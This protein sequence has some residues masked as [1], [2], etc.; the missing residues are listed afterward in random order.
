MATGH[1]HADERDRE[2]THRLL[3]EMFSPETPD[4]RRDAIREIVAECPECAEHVES[5]RAVRDMVRNCCGHARAP[6]PLRERI[7]ASITT[8]SYTEVRFR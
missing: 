8:I 5:E 7:I 3:C 2:E 4:E 1:S 6:E